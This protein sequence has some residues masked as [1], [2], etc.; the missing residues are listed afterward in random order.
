MV[1]VSHKD[2]KFVEA[3]TKD[4]FTGKLIGLM[5]RRLDKEE[6]LLLEFSNEG[7]WGIW[8]LFVPQDLGLLF[9]NENKEIVDMKEAKK[10]SLNP[11]TWKIYKPEEK[12]KYVLEC[13]TEK[14]NTIEKGEKLKW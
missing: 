1:E 6:G 3:Q 11:E 4:S 12:C 9:L 13:N 2:E 10:I 5:F 14:L 7:K 8:M